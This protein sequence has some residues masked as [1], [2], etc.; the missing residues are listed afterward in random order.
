M[1]YISEIVQFGHKYFTYYIYLI[2][3]KYFKYLSF[4]FNPHIDIVKYPCMKLAK[5]QKAF[6][7]INVTALPFV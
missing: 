5:V 7:F 4:L 3:F 1:S 2:L 6:N